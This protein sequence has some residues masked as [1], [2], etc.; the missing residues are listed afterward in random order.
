MPPKASALGSTIIGIT[1]AFLSHCGV[2]TAARALETQ[3]ISRNKSHAVP[4]TRPTA[5]PQIG[6]VN[7]GSLALRAM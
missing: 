5:G 3:K 4:P 6:V 1:R 7:G 2:W